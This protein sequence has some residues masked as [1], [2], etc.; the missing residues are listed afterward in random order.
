MIEKVLSTLQIRAYR[1]V[2]NVL[3]TTKKYLDS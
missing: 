2:W 1:S 3:V